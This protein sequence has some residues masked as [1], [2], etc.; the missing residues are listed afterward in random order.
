M[1]NFS[2][3]MVRRSERNPRAEAAGGKDSSIESSVQPREEMESNTVSSDTVTESPDTDSSDELTE[4]TAAVS[5]PSVSESPGVRMG[6]SADA[7]PVPEVEPED[8][9]D[10]PTVNNP[11]VNTYTLHG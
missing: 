2:H 4:L 7:V 3:P 5:S 11:K 1:S 9:T 8:P 6:E 10:H